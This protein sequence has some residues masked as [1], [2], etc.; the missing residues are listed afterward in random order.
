MSLVLDTFKDKVIWDLTQ[1]DISSFQH[2]LIRA[3]NSKQILKYCPGQNQVQYLS[4][5]E[6][7][8]DNMK[9]GGPTSMPDTFNIAVIGLEYSCSY[10]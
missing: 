7:I 1:I 5:T 2:P 9:C 6:S 8:W 4:L 10:T 3:Q